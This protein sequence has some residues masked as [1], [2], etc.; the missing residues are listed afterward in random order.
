MTSTADTLHSERVN[1]EKELHVIQ[2]E[3]Q[4][5]KEA[6]SAKANEAEIM[7]NRLMQ[8][9]QNIELENGMIR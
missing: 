1:L 2:I 7:R 4:N 6:F 8:E 9:I 3:I 5:Q